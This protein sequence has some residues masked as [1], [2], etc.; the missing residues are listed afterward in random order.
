MLRFVIDM[1]VHASLFKRRR[2]APEAARPFRARAFPWFPGLAL[3]A[4]TGF[5][6]DF[7]FA[8]SRERRACTDSVG[9][10][11]SALQILRLV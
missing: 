7:T 3:A 5:F 1:S 9:A 6:C 8:Q 10:Q 11:L 2:D 4:G